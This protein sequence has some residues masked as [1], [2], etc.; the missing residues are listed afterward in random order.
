MNHRDASAGDQIVK[1]PRECI[2]HR[3]QLGRIARAKSANT[4]VAIAA[5]LAGVPRG[6]GIRRAPDG[7]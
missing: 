1:I 4:K 7:D 3:T 5:V 6:L 2:L